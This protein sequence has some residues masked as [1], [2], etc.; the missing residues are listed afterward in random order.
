[1]KSRAFK[2]N[3][4]W[5]VFVF[6]FLF[7]SSTLHAQVSFFQPPAFSGSGDVFAADF[8]GDGRPDLLCADG[9][10]N[11]GNG[12]GTFTLGAAV[13]GI[14]LAVADFNGDGKP[15]VLEQG[16][17]TL[18]VLLGNGDGTF[19]APVSTPSGASLAAVAA[20]DLNGDGKIDVV[21]VFNN[22]LIVYIGHGDGTFAPGISY[23]MNVVSAGQ[24]VL[25]LGDLNGDN[26]TDIV[27]STAGDVAAG[28]EIAFLGNGDGTFQT[29]KSSMGVPYPSSAVVGDF[30]GDGKGDLLVSGAALCNGT[31]TTPATTYILLGNGNGSFLAP[32]PTFP[33]GAVAAADLNGDGKL[34]IV[35]KSD[36]SV[37]QISL[38]NGDGTFSTPAN[39]YVLEL[40]IGPFGGIA[41]AGIAIADFNLD[42]KLDVAIGNVVLLGNGNGTL[43]GVSLGPI[44]DTPVALVVGAFDKNPGTGRCRRLESTGFSGFS[45]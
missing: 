40:P 24:T 35:L 23:N 29:A 38:N 13:S 22:S 1:M 21:G 33:G 31:C 36:P 12:D 27:V 8:N 6:L 34:D 9:T 44:P 7:V 45:F 32:A 15:D 20:A 5:F 25:S 39:D 30:N 19:Q 3:S 43:R 2:L 11:L 26:K 37:A 41:G 4:P 14:P 18:L 16:T 28:Q 10:L 17:G 42:G